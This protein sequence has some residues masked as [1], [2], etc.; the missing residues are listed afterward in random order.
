[1]RRREQRQILLLLSFWFTHGVAMEPGV[2]PA[3]ERI[4]EVHPFMLSSVEASLQKLKDN[5]LYSPDVDAEDPIVQE[6]REAFQNQ[7]E[8]GTW[9]EGQWDDGSRWKSSTRC[10]LGLY[11]FGTGDMDAGEKLINDAALKDGSTWASYYLGII[12]LITEEEPD[13]FVALEHFKKAAKANPE[14]IGPNWYRHIMAVAGWH[15]ADLKDNWLSWLDG[16]LCKRS[17]VSLSYPLA[18]Y[19]RKCQDTF[20][21][22]LLCLEVAAR[23]KN[24][25]Q[26]TAIKELYHYSVHNYDGT[27]YPEAQKAERI[28]RSIGSHTRYHLIQE[29]IRL[30][31]ER[32]NGQRI[33]K[34]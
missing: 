25:H 9:I 13:A 29:A 30:L 27:R 16:L 11:V 31:D 18:V 26:R 12:E 32:K 5:N 21:A 17:K 24:A 7:V 20:G 6:A 10:G 33:E 14:H 8:Q 3:D 23:H 34:D 28:L 4:I 19:A 15:A 1:M 22:E 2:E